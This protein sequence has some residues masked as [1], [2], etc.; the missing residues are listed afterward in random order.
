[1]AESTTT[2][3]AGSAG[4]TMP[5]ATFTRAGRTVQEVSPLGAATATLAN[6][7]ASAASV[8]LAAANA[9]RQG[10]IVY[11]DS[12]SVLMVKYGTAATATSFTYLLQPGGTLEMGQVVY[13]GVVTGIWT[14]AAGAA[15]VTE[16][17]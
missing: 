1:M 15:R 17:A 16:L 2:V 4:A 8:T 12:A 3:Y 5:V 9:E 10:L 6:V 7:A 14:A 11:N 13:R